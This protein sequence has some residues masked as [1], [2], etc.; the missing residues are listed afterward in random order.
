MSLDVNQNKIWVDE[1][2]HVCKR[3]MKTWLKD[4]KTE[5]YFESF[6]STLKKK[7]ME[8]NDFNII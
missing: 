6:I 3:S 8:I 5:I 4:N 1:G 2:T 7:K